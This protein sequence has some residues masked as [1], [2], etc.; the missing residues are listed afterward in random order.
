MEPRL[1]RVWLEIVQIASTIMFSDVEDNLIWKFNSNGIYSSQSLYMIINFR[2]VTPVHS[3]SIWTL[4]I[5]PRVQFFLWLLTNNKNPTRDNLA[6]RQKAEDKTCLFCE[7]IET[8]QHLFF[9][10]AVAKEIW[11]RISIVMGREVG[12]S[13]DSIGTC[14]LIDKFCLL[15]RNEMC[16]QNTTWKSME[17]LLMKAA[18]LAQNWLIMC[19]KEKKEELRYLASQQSTSAR[20]PERLMR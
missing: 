3:P 9:D 5:P 7:E 18:C 11:R 20:N 1:G 15:L 4:R 19:P 13:L 12:S 16:F 2:G 14:W 17:C 10:C 6:K 8:S